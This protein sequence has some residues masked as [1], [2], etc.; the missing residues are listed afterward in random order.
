MSIF[1][2]FLT[3]VLVLDCA[4]LVLLV[5]LQLP[6]KE[7][8]AGAA[9]G[10]GTTDVLFGAGAGNVLTK[11]TAYSAGIFL[12]LCLILAILQNRQHRDAGGAIG[13]ALAA[14]ATPATQTPATPAA[15]ATNPAV[16]LTITPPTT[17]PALPAEGTA[18]P[19]APA[20]VEPKK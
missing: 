10:G 5:L 2:G 1:I 20:P 4:F 7:A 3:V 13:K 6:K 19:P 16:P 18:T 8:G 17:A 9:F 15:P 12:G 14:P 11:A